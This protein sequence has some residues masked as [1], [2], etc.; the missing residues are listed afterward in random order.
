MSFVSYAFAIFF[1]IVAILYFILPHRL[2]NRML[3]VASYI[4]YGYWDW[5]FLFLLFGTSLLDFYLA[6][7]A[8]P[9]H[10]IPSA[11]R[12]QKLA[13]ALS[14]IVNLGVLGIFKYLNFFIVS[15]LD[16]AAQLGVEHRVST[17]NII[18]PVGISFF[19]FQRM[20]YVFDV[21]RADINHTK[22]LWDFLLYVSFFPQLVAGPIERGA[23]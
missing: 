15:L 14:V 22:K 17:L 16:V 7:L 3:L 10:P 5:R 19:T 1:S 9:D 2:Q 13:L 11:R 21:C 23:A 4:F 20:S 6:A 18:L 8:S 12:R